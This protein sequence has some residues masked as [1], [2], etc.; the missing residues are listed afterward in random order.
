M[1]LTTGQRR[2]LWQMGDNQRLV[3]LPEE[4]RIVF[5]E[6][7]CVTIYEKTIDRL[8][9]LGLIEAEPGSGNERFRLTEQGGS[10]VVRMRTEPKPYNPCRRQGAPDGP[11]CAF[12]ARPEGVVT[13]CFH[14]MR[15][16]LTACICGAEHYAC[17][18]CIRQ[19]RKLVGTIP[20]LKVGVGPCP[21][22]RMPAT[23]EVA[24]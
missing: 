8:L 11:S 1:K 4:G 10:L 24:R 16:Y 18:R 14:P 15:V 6:R 17:K 3:R 22:A 2:I 19:R 21:L 5:A 20:F 7:T 12:C 23:A 13:G 9:G